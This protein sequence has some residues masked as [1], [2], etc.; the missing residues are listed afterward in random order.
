MAKL[1]HAQKSLKAVKREA[2]KL[3]KHHLEALLNKALVE[4]QTKKT[5]A[6]TYLIRA[7]RNRQ[8]YARF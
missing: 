1:R 8:C 5:K 2:D 4:N 7:E 3:C 6:L